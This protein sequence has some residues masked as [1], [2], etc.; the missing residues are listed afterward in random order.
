MEL[1]RPR[2]VNFLMKSTLLWSLLMKFTLLLNLL[3]KFTLLAN[4]LM[5]SCLWP[6]APR[7][8][9]TGGRVRACKV[10]PFF[11]GFPNPPEL[12]LERPRCSRPPTPGLQRHVASRQLSNLY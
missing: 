5:P 7:R 1:E 8:T 10:K 9:D 4:L 11:L 12:G 2:L 6:L 3:M